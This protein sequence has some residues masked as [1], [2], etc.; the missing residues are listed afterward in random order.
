MPVG[1]PL[2][3]VAAHLPS[4]LHMDPEA[5]YS[6]ARQT[7]IEIEMAEKKVGHSNT[8]LI[9]D[10]NMNLFEKGMTAADGFHGMLDANLVK[11]ASRTVQ[12]NGHSYF[13]NPM[14]NRIGDNSAGRQEPISIMKAAILLISFGTHLIKC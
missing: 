7:R 13:Y 6:V 8:L 2:L 1:R 14:W 11:N 4:K 10:L 9:G 12:G 5:Q 3:I